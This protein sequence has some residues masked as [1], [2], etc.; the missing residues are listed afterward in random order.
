M[1]T[2]DEQFNNVSVA[3]L[4]E[5]VKAI[6]ADLAAIQ[7]EIHEQGGAS[8]ARLDAL[9]QSIAQEREYRA[10]NDNTLQLQ[11]QAAEAR[12]DAAR[13]GLAARHEAAMAK[14]QMETEGKIANAVQATNNLRLQF[15]VTCGVVGVL[16]IVF[17]FLSNT[18]HF[19]GH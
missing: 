14:L 1:P 13:M 4:E 15:Q 9:V 11:L 6:R 18:F 7:A 17:T 3:R 2:T 12:Q 16:W 8:A 10:E 5:Q 19:F